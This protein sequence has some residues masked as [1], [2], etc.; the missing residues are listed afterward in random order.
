MLRV[1]FMNNFY[2]ANFGAKGERNGQVEKSK[3]IFNL[4]QEIQPR[5]RKIDLSKNIFGIHALLNPIRTIPNV[6]VSLGQNGIFVFLL[7]MWVRIVLF[8]KKS[9]IIYF[10]VGGWLANLLRNST[11][12]R[13][14]MR[15]VYV[16]Y[17]ESFSLKME[18]EALGYEAKLFPNFRESS[19]SGPKD[20]INNSKL[21]LVFCSRVRR[22]KGVI[23]A[24]QLVHRLNQ[25]GQDSTLDIYGPIDDDFDD[26]HKQCDLYDYCVSYKGEYYA[27]EAT[28]I[29]AAYDFLI[30]PTYYYGECM[31]GVIV[32]SFSVG[33]P[34][35]CSDWRYL[36]EY[37]DDEVDG[38]VCK[39]SCFVDQALSKLEGIRSESRYRTM[40]LKAYERF[41]NSYS[42]TKARLLLSGKE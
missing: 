20:L 40:S 31:P 26:F 22:D 30:F 3:Q 8:R 17:V 41:E 33:T 10:V 37:V 14:L 25:L 29:L 34:V 35:V 42:I 12:L 11:I 1:I 13:V 15:R 38:F 5:L 24:I 19:C 16:M 4:L 6:Y 36:S 21:K 7:V 28:A 9:T 18:L 32:E 27:E 23:D 39:L 2:V